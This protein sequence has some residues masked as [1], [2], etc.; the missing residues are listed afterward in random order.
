MGSE[1]DLDLP[2][3]LKAV[4]SAVVTFAG[5]GSERRGLMNYAAAAEVVCKAWNENRCFF[6]R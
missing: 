6:R 3:R 5:S 4:E 2:T 1:E